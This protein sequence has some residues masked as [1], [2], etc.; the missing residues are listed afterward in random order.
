[1]T[2]LAVTFIPVSMAETR[3]DSSS[4]RLLQQG[5]EYALDVFVGGDGGGFLCLN[6]CCFRLGVERLYETV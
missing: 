5:T 6:S 3:V 4:F 2:D 1:M